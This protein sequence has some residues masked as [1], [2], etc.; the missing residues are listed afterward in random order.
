MKSLPSISLGSLK[1]EAHRDTLTNSVANY[2]KSNFLEDELE[3]LIDFR[4]SAV[5]LKECAR[6]SGDAKLQVM[7]LKQKLDM[8]VKLLKE[9]VGLVGR[10]ISDLCNG[11]EE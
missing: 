1:L 4:D 10:E 5:T 6:P 7:R 3:F 2:L 9:E 8:I 11:E